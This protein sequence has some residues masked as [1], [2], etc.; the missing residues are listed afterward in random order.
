MSSLGAGVPIGGGLGLVAVGDAPEG[1]EVIGLGRGLVAVGDAPEGVE[2]IG[3]GRG[4]VATVD[5]CLGKIA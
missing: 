1:V 5:S 3:L 4:L 2:V